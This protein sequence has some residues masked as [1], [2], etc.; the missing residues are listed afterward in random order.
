MK[1]ADS[2]LLSLFMRGNEKS[3]RHY[4]YTYGMATLH[5]KREDFRRFE[6]RE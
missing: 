4:K 6:T 2:V 1:I 5:L 3:H